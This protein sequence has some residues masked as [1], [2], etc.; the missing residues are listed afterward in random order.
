[1]SS[2]F[3]IILINTPTG[4][5]ALKLPLK[6][7]AILGTDCIS[8]TDF[9]RAVLRGFFSEEEKPQLHKTKIL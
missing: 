8:S 7:A 3:K 6:V 1:M 4:L 2:N 5:G 9:V